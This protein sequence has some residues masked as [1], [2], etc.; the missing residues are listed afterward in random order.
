M[1]IVSFIIRGGWSLVKIR[2]I[3]QLISYGKAYFILLQET[4]CFSIDDKF[5]SYL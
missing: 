2:R 3:N 4:K 1:N 5:V